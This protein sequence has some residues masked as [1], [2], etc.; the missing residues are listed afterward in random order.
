MSIQMRYEKKIKE[1]QDEYD[2]LV[3]KEKK[4]Q[5]LKKKK[6]KMDIF[7]PKLYTIDREIENLT[8]EI[9]M[10]KSKKKEVD[11]MFRVKDVIRKRGYNFLPGRENNSNSDSGMMKFVSKNT[12]FSDDSLLE[13]YITAE[14]GDVGKPI[15][16]N[17]IPDEYSKCK[18][19]G[20]KVLHK[21][22]TASVICVDCGVSVQ[23]T[24]IHSEEWSD[25]VT[26]SVPF[27]YDRVSHFKEHLN[28]LQGLEAKEIPEDLLNDIRAEMNKNRITSDKLSRTKLLEILRKL[29]KSDYYCNVFSIK[30]RLTG[31]KPPKLPRH[32][33]DRLIALFKTIQKPFELNKPKN[34]KNFFSYHY[35]IH[36]LL[37]LI[38][39]TDP[40]ANQYIKYFPLLKSREK[41]IIQDMTWRTV[42][43][44]LGWTYKRST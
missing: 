14:S 35:V 25:T 44:S 40:D 16:A 37:E 38:G 31:E 29:K 43:E 39:E 32:L 12:I 42:C 28:Q 26:I 8:D 22:V 3:L 24:P 6:L 19:C 23:I 41:L 18:E 1:F 15:P 33:E 7:D 30:Y 2:S 5:S 17:S 27:S 10:I 9:E 34:R 21:T 13:E 4:L 20:G 11:Y 36:K